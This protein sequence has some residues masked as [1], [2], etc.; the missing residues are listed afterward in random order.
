MRRGYLECEDIFGAGESP[1]LSEFLMLYGRGGGKKV[2]VRGVDTKG[3]PVTRIY[4]LHER[5]LKGHVYGSTYKECEKLCT[6][7]AQ[8]CVT[9]LNFRLADLKKL[10]PTKLFR[11]SKWAKKGKGDRKVREYLHRCIAIFGDKLPGFDMTAAERELQTWAPIMEAHHEDE[12]FFKGLR[13][14]MNTTEASSAR[15]AKLMAISLLHY[16]I[17]WDAALA[18]WR[19]KP[20]RLAKS[21]VFAAAERK[22]KEI[23]LSEDEVQEKEDRGCEWGEEQ[24]SDQDGEDGFA[25]AGQDNAADNPFLSEDEGDEADVKLICYSLCR[26]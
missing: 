2:R 12:G 20:K 14:F 17:D 1:V 24:D 21:P 23:E 16:E 9:R 18:K 26:L 8:E 5:H 13:N 22:R 3:H 19:E 7:F 15:L 11:A 25:G 6:K 10:S 4:K